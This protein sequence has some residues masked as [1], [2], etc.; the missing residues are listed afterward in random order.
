MPKLGVVGN[1]SQVFQAAQPAAPQQDGTLDFVMKLGEKYLAGKVAEKQQQMFVA[2]MQ[3]VATGEALSDIKKDDPPFASLFGPTAT[4]AGASAM[5]KIK[6]VDDFVTEQ[7]GKLPELAKLDPQTA[8][9]QMMEGMNKHLTGDPSVDSAIQSRIVEQLPVLMKAQTKANYAYVQDQNSRQWTAMVSSAAHTVQGAA[10]N[11]ARGTLNQDDFD[12]AKGNALALLQKPAGMDD[13]T[14]QKSVA[15]YAKLQLAQG[16]HWIDRWMNESHD[17]QP[18][19]YASVLSADDQLDIVKAR[20][21]AESNTA[22]Q[23]GFNQYGAAI[24]EVMGGAVARSPAENQRRVNEL[25]A[26]YMAET[27]STTGIIDAKAA[28]QM[29]TA[30]YKRAYARADAR[31]DALYKQNLKNASDREKDKQNIRIATTMFGGGAGKFVAASGLPSGESDA[32]FWQG[33]NEKAKANPAEAIN[34]AITNYNQGA[35]YVNPQLQNALTAPFRLL[36][37]GGPIGPEFDQAQQVYAEMVKQPGGQAAA[38]AYLGEDNAIKMDR[39]NGF[40]ASGMLK[41]EAQQAAFGKPLIKG[42]KLDTK[43]SAPEVDKALKDLYRVGGANQVLGFVPE[44]DDTNKAIVQQ[45]V[46]PIMENLINNL[47]AGI[48]EAAK[49]AAPVVTRE[50]DILGNVAIRKSSRQP[51]L[52][53]A[54]GASQEDAGKVMFETMQ[55]EAAKA[56]VNVD[57]NG[58]FQHLNSK[59]TGQELRD[60]GVSPDTGKFGTWDAWVHRGSI[61]VQRLNDA[62]GPDGKP[63]QLY[64]GT[65]TTP[66]GETASFS[67]DSNQVRKRL[68]ETRIKPADRGTLKPSLDQSTILP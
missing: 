68:E 11:V 50:L 34:Y 48:P 59:V 30:V 53:Q 33:F 37:G 12:R 8:G 39:Y 45:A 35:S 55:L 63:M 21:S 24:A 52:A 1:N 29:Q 9:K 19:F 26:Q 7:Y 62:T 3:R 49:R 18:S 47:G 54:I 57:L 40:L 31:E 42:P 5:A 16:N 38:D 4:I 27:G 51:S 60:T 28:T 46:Q 22:K 23:Y 2:G 17:G 6:N 66:D 64:H 36:E 61:R 13:K 15:D 43:E 10:L 25:N 67:F 58:F 20:D 56:G 41:Q 65:I 14:Y 32:L 44:M